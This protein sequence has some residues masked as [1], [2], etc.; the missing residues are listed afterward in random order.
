MR[1]AVAT[2]A[3]ALTVVGAGLTARQ[4][5]TEA[6]EREGGSPHPQPPAA[7]FLVREQA[8]RDQRDAAAVLVPQSAAFD[9]AYGKDLEAGPVRLWINGTVQ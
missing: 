2:F 4:V 5:M 9:A 7:G 3:L 1:H 8:I 6:A